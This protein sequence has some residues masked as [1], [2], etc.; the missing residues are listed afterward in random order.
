LKG[1]FRE[2]IVGTVIAFCITPV[3]EAVQFTICGNDIAERGGD[4]KKRHSFWQHLSSWTKIGYGCT[5]AQAEV[6]VLY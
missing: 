4:G 5:K 2:A 3:F 6:T 1:F